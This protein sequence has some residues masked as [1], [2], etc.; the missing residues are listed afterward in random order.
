M[1]MPNDDM[2]LPR[3]MVY[4][5]PI[6]EFKHKRKSRNMKRSGSSDQDQTRFK[7]RAQGQEEPRSDKV[8]LEKGGGSQ[9][10]KPMCVT[11]GKR[12]YGKCLSGNS[13]C[14]CCGKDDHKVM[15]RPT[16]AARG[17]EGKQ[18]ARNLP[19]DDAPNKWRCCGLLTIGENSNEDDDGKTLYLFSVLS[20]F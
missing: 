15:D 7:M 16:I 18:V 8:K 14:Y 6:E 12:P 20:S 3:L 11:L 4:A 2:T 9:N 17:R 1:D 19:K 13:G 10:G 5:Q